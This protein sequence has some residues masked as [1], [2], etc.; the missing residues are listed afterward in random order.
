M[1]I[2]ALLPDLHIVGKFLEFMFTFEGGAMRL[3]YSPVVRKSLEMLEEV[4]PF[5]VGRDRVESI[6]ECIG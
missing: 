2:L 5:H 4:D 6:R 3:F 1:G